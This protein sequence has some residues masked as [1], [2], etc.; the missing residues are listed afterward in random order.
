MFL[1][2]YQV[3]N[4][5]KYFLQK[6]YGTYCECDNFSCDRSGGAL[7]GGHGT[8]DCGTC[9]CFPDWTGE[10]CDCHATNSTCIMAGSDEICSGRGVCECGQCKCSEEND[11]RYS[12]KYCQKCPVS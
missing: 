8:C 10:S 2:F 12:G 9:K 7:C 3:V 1:L 5:I 6:V 4:S 11:F